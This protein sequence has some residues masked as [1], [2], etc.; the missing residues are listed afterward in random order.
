[1][2][3][4]SFSTFWK[5]SVFAKSH[6]GQWQDLSHFSITVYIFSIIAAWYFPINSLPCPLMCQLQQEWNKSQISVG[7]PRQ[8]C[9][10]PHQSGTTLNKSLSAANHVSVRS[11]AA[12]ERFG[13]LK[14]KWLQTSRVNYYPQGILSWTSLFWWTAFFIVY[15]M[16]R[17]LAEYNHKYPGE[18]ER[19]R[20]KQE[21]TLGLTVRFE[22]LNTFFLIFGVND[23]LHVIGM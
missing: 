8:P 11:S 7:R 6:W 17:I 9:H 18:W 13:S 3:K 19:K 12:L 1:M 20:E 15:V 5:L 16:W 22:W 14:R 21:E 2:L 10:K 23:H 4:L